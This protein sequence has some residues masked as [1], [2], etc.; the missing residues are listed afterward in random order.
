MVFCEVLRAGRVG[1]GKGEGKIFAG[2]KFPLSEEGES[3]A[4]LTH[5]DGQTIEGVHDADGEG[6]IGDLGIAEVRF[7]RLESAVRCAGGGD[8]RHRLGPFQRGAFAL[9]ELMA[10]A[11]ARQ[12][13]QLGM[14]E[15]A[16][17]AALCRAYPGSRRSR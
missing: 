10:D 1:A 17:C 11:P 13:I 16:F 4:L 6:Q 2:E 15:A 14:A 8:Q 12:R 3:S 7:Q 9:A 5:A